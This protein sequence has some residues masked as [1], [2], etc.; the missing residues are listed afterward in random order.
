[1]LCQNLFSNLCLHGRRWCNAGPVG[2]H[3]FTTEGL[4][5]IGTFYHKYLTVQ[6]QIRTC[7]GKSG[8][9]LSCACLGG[10]AFQ[11]L[12]LGVISLSDGRIQLM[13]A[14][15]IISFKFIINLRRCFK[16]LLQAVCPNKGRRTVHLIEIYNLLG[17]I[18]IAVV[19]IQFLLYQ[20][21]TEH[22]GKFFC[23]HGL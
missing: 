6:I 4:L 2:T 12:L 18:N 21:F 8:S 1:M 16:L 15:G 3:Y 13:T 11:S 5:L 9:P 19:V 7:H 10:H 14:A 22:D 20:F 17:N 23:C